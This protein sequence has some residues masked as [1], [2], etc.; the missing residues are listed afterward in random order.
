MAEN[1]EVKAA[2]KSVD[3][4]VSVE[5]EFNEIGIAIAKLM[6]TSNS[7]LEDGFQAGQD[8]PTVLMGS[9]KELSAAIEGS[10]KLS[11]AFKADP[12]AAIAGIVIPVIKAVQK[13][14]SRAK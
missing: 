1:K 3:V 13:I 7:A 2:A 9:Y 8:I 14:R 12:V 10:D 5:K 6:E 4:A 11:D